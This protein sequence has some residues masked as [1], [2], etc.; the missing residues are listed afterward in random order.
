[1]TSILSGLRAAYSQIVDTP[2]ARAAADR[3]RANRDPEEARMAD[4]APVAA[5]NAP[6]AAVGRRQAQAAYRNVCLA[7]SQT[8]TASA[9]ETAVRG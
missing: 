4:R 3:I 7:S 2:E 5:Q 6:P 8:E 1:V 9:P